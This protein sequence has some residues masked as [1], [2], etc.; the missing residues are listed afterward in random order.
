[1][2]LWFR[3]LAFIPKCICLTFTGFSPLGF[4]F[5]LM[6]GER[7]KN[8]YFLHIKLRSLNAFNSEPYPKFLPPVA[9]GSGVNTA[10]HWRS[11][12]GIPLT[13]R[14]EA[15]PRGRSLQRG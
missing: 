8:D 6:R 13:A 5:E 2:L 9:A 11:S 15:L 14:A 3:F 4:I 10:A 12:R 1:M 7:R